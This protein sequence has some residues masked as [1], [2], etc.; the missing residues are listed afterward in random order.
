MMFGYTVPHFMGIYRML[1]T[2]CF[3]ITMCLSFHGKTSPIMCFLVCD[4]LF[5]FVLCVLL[6]K[7]AV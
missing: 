3:I 5:Y 6:K 2:E 7:D 1:F 4:S